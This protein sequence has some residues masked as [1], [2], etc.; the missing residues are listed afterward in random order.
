MTTFP[1]I[2]R[3]EGKFFGTIFTLFVHEGSDV[4][5]QSGLLLEFLGGTVARQLIGVVL[6]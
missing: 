3:A 2:L 5:E 6:V 4:V 1:E